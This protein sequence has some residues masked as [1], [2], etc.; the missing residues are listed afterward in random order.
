[1]I[2]IRNLSVDFDDFHLREVDLEVEAGDF[3]VLLGPTGAGKTVLLEAVT[4][5]APVTAGSIRI[6]GKEITALP[7]EKRHAG[8]VYQDYALFPHLSVEENIRFGLKYMRQAGGAAGRHEQRDIEERFDFLA[9]ELALHSLLHRM[10]ETL[11]G[12]EMQRTALA[13]A[14][15]TDPEVLLLDEPLSA[16][17][18]AFREEIRRMLKRLHA[19]TGKTFLMVTHDFSE[20]LSL[21]GR[22]AVINNG[23]IE[24]TG[25]IAEIFRKPTSPFVAGFVGMKNVLEAEFFESGTLARTG[26]LE[27]RL[28]SLEDRPAGPP[29]SGAS[30][31]TVEH[32]FLA[33][34]PEDIVL[35]TEPIR[36]SMRNSFTARVQA[37]IDRGMAC[38]VLLGAGSTKLT[39][40][41][42][43]GS[44]LDLELHEGKEIWCSFKATAVH[45][46]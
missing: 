22:G 14:L 36:S 5:I 24:Q 11:S 45:R 42:T 19:D 41:V 23:R 33:V 2:S 44:V 20:A 35:S 17:D 40:H 10:P 30:G 1:M 21:G 16:L 3:F 18:P 29:S 8:I 9:A 34:R 4:G 46:F 15:I 28:A 12:G 25:K 6:S 37:V 39:A 31:E 43:R 26:G 32:G 13:R 7:P 27:L 38:E